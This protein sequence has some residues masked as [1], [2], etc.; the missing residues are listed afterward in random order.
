MFSIIITSIDRMI[1]SMIFYG[2]S[3]QASNLGS[4][5]Y[6]TLASISAVDI[7]ANLLVTLLMY[8]YGRKKVLFLFSLLAG[9][10]CIS[11]IF[12]PQSSPL[13]TI[14]AIFGKS[15]ISASYTLMYVYSAEIFPTV[16][17][18]TGVGLCTVFSRV[19]GIIA[20][21][22]IELVIH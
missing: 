14:V 2:L 5:T 21:H 16:L 4:N 11:T 18:S 12:I 20:P 10:S 6:L 1:D 8:F 15:N 3:F 9:L 19:G 7:P 17:R 13:F 22:L